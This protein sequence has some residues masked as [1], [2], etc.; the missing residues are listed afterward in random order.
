VPLSA[1]LERAGV[2]G[3]AHS[4][5]VTGVTGY[6]RRFSLDEARS[7]LLAVAV[8]GQPMSDD[9]GFPARLVMPGHRGFDW[10]KWV[11]QI[12]V[13]EGGDIWQLPLPLG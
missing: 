9:H 8:A 10:V 3:G 7:A 5:T 2:K 12:T 4:V 1:L 6:N 11:T 13:N